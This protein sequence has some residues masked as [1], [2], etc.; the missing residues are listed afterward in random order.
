MNKGQ[1]S[2]FGTRS[3]PRKGN[4]MPLLEIRIQPV[5]RDALVARPNISPENGGTAR[6]F[7]QHISLLK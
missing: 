3:L 7:T 1:H 6:A 4:E 2:N 5:L